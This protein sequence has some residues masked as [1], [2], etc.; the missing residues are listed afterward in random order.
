MEKSEATK[1][2]V[3]AQD[4]GES[5][6]NEKHEVADDGDESAKNSSL[7]D[8]SK[9]KEEEDSDTDED[10]LQAAANWAKES[11]SET[12]SDPKPSTTNPPSEKIDTQ[13]KRNVWSLHITQLSYDATDFEIREAFAS[14][15]CMVASVR[16]V[17]DRSSFPKTFR[18][19]AFVDVE[20]EES[21]KKAL[22]LDKFMLMGRRINVRPTRT[23]S[24]L[25]NI[26][27]RTKELVAAKI[28]QSTG[29][30]VCRE[31]TEGQI[32]FISSE[33]K[34][35][36]SNE[37]SGRKSG[38]SSDNKESPSV[39]KALSTSKN[40]APMSKKE[41]TRSDAQKK[42]QKLSK[43]ERNRRAAII[44]SSRRRQGK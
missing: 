11:K 9:L 31:E 42:H 37:K 7:K 14:K 27:Q 6:V 5:D 22:T 26:V 43:K 18:G 15:G 36:R 19:V 34:R 2:K 10:L 1:Q 24:E 8:G 12:A 39:T 32:T 41:P 16:L 17:Y 3:A 21:Y 4:E 23:K 38:S 28:E 29:R 30:K 35:K 44:M 33:K 13:Q 20:D 40:D 25:A